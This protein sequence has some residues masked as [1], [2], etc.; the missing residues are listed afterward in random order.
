[1]CKFRFRL[2]DYPKEFDMELIKKYGFYRTHPKH[3]Q[4]LDGV[5]RDHL[6]S[7]KDGFAYGILPI[8]VAHPANCRLL[9]HYDNRKKSGASQITPEELWAL[10]ARWEAKYGR[11]YGGAYSGLW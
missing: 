5:S 3:D 2:S 8:W 11:Y 6:L 4:N 7:V 10:I 1:M 9:L